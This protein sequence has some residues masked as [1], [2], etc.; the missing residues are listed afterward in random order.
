M[1]SDQVDFEEN[2]KKNFASSR[3]SGEIFFSFLY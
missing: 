1:I 2:N 3:L